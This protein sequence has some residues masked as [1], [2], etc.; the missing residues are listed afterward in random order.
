MRIKSS[1]NVLKIY[2]QLVLNIHRGLLSRVSLFKQVIKDV[3]LTEPLLFLGF[4]PWYVHE[5]AILAY[6]L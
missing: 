5:S 3:N 6:L 1:D 4:P 2:H